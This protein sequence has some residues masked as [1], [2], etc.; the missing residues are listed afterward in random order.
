MM[1]IFRLMTSALTLH[2]RVRDRTGTCIHSRRAAQACHLQ[3]PDKGMAVE[4]LQ[5]VSGALSRPGW[6]SK[7][8]S[9]GLQ[10]AQRLEAL[11]LEAFNSLRP[12][13]SSEMGRQEAQA[14]EVRS[15]GH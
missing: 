9:Q 11:V 12:A 15:C 7:C 3:D 5:S 13:L 4:I 10:D 8:L 6:L 1:V 14:A 2:G